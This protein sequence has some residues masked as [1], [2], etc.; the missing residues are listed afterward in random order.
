MTNVPNR[1]RVVCM[2]R[3]FCGLVAATA[4]TVGCAS[5][6]SPEQ[7]LQSTVGDGGGGASDFAGQPCVEGAAC[8][9]GNQGACGAGKVACQGGAATC[10]PASTTQSC[11]SGAAAT[12]D[13]GTCKSGTQTC[14]GALGSCGGE[15]LP[16]A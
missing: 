11:Y 8:T 4:L 3:W 10:V 2:G 15:V 16:A 14:I 5:A 7:V 1:R 12:R 13:V 9:T 6:A